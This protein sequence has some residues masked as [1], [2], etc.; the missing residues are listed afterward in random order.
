MEK[1]RFSLITGSSV[2][3]EKILPEQIVRE[4]S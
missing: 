3:E 4:G 2:S 1:W